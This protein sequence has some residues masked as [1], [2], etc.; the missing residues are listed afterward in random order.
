[1]QAEHR[2]FVAVLKENGVRVLQLGDLLQNILRMR[3]AASPRF[4]CC[5]ASLQPSLANILLDFC[6]PLMLRDIL[7]GGI[8]PSELADITG[9][10][11]AHSHDPEDPFL[12]EPIPNSYFTGPSRRTGG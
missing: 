11:L 6:S 7:L 1:M 8:T 4:R 2:H 10:R 3:S 12:L 5:N 9:K